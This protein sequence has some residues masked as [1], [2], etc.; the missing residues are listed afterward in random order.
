M[1]YTPDLGSGGR[2]P[3][4]VRILSLVRKQK[5]LKKENENVVIFMFLDKKVVMAQ[6]CPGGP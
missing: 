4:E 3:L 5:L 1:V 2:N 6:G